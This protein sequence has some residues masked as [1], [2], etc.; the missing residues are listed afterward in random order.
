[1]IIKREQDI[2][3]IEMQILQN[4]KYQGKIHLYMLHQ[5]KL[6]IQAEHIIVKHM[7]IHME[8]AK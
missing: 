8:K 7:N 3:H 6:Q 1:M 4:I 2:I 5:E